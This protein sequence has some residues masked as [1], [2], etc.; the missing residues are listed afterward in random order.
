MTLTNILLPV[1]FSERSIDAA[2]YA[3][4][5][6]CRFHATLHIVHVVDMRL[7]GVAGL[8][9]DPSA[10][11]AFASGAESFGRRE[12]DA[13]MLSDLR[14]LNVQRTLLYG[15]PGRQIVRQAHARHADLIVMPTHGY[16][17][18]REFLLGSVTAKVLHDA[19]CPVWTGVHRQGGPD[20]ASVSFGKTL[21]AFNPWE[22]NTGALKWAW[23][24][25]RE[26]GSAV[27]IVNAMAPVYGAGSDLEQ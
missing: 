1:D 24:F 21:C 25:S 5:L 18:F 22:G 20:M 3:K 2:Q 11:S 16:G 27:K 4:A 6:A 8:G 14:N 23:D 9:D 19:E 13:F 12:L 7:Y 26:A 10:A 17:K 15:D